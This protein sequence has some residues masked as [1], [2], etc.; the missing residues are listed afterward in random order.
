MAPW[1]A[2]AFERIHTHS[3]ESIR[4]HTN[5]LSQPPQPKS[6]VEGSSPSPS[7][8]AFIG[9][10]THS[11][12]SIRIPTHSYA[13]IRIHDIPRM[14]PS[15]SPS[16]LSAGAL[17]GARHLAAYNHPSPYASI[18]NLYLNHEPK[19]LVEGSS[20]SPSPDA[21][22]RIRT[23]S[24]AFERILTYLALCECTL[25]TFVF[26]DACGAAHLK[27]VHSVDWTIAGAYSCMGTTRRWQT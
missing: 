7:P 9:I 6:L 19:S 10:H 22:I 20:P 14:P 4:I 3:Y 5:P 17:P 13:F 25:S 12:A 2:I 26:S 27:E 1:C 18:R 23:H 11:Y 21:F 8:D 16:T 15:P 24:H